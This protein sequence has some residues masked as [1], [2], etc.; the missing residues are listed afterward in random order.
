M[1]CRYCGKQVLDEAYMC[2]SCGKM[3]KE[4]P[5]PIVEPMQIEEKPQQKRDKYK[6]PAMVLSIVTLVLSV[7]QLCFVFGTLSTLGVALFGSA[8]SPSDDWAALGWFGVVWFAYGAWALMALS[9]A[10]TTTGIIGL[11][12]GRKTENRKMKKLSVAAFV[13]SMIVLVFALFIYAFVMY[14]NIASY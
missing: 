14:N 11:V 10:S 13:L 7:V 9:P 5:T 12:F 8:V 3:L 1:F 2:P 4:L 6:V